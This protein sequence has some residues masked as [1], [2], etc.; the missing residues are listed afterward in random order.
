M[1]AHFETFIYAWLHLNFLYSVS[2]VHVNQGCYHHWSVALDPVWNPNPLIFNGCTR[3]GPRIPND[4][5]PTLKHGVT[6]A[7]FEAQ[8]C[9]PHPSIQIYG[10]RNSHF[11]PDVS[12]SWPWTSWSSRDQLVDRKSASRPVNIMQHRYFTWMWA[13]SHV[14]VNIVNILLCVYR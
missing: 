9:F 12:L 3:Q 11:N 6:L 2:E 1:F 7:F 10:T 5:T 4:Q 8:E 14:G 13:F